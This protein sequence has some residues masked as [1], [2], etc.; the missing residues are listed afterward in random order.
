MSDFGDFI[1]GMLLFIGAILLIRYWWRTWHSWWGSDKSSYVRWRMGLAPIPD[2]DPDEYSR[3]LS[4]QFRRILG[5]AHGLQGAWDSAYAIQ[6]DRRLCLM[7][8]LVTE[9]AERL[10]KNHQLCSP[11]Y[12][13]LEYRT[14][15][16]LVEEKQVDDGYIVGYDIFVEVSPWAHD[17]WP[18]E[19]RFL[20]A[21]RDF[22]PI[23]KAK[24]IGAYRGNL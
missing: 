2:R 22:S 24:L 9:G 13:I 11:L 19:K 8:F 18:R 3:Y 1:G 16:R 5:D 17:S 15:L 7:E 6:E 23:T 20:G 14:P 4:L 10:R 12:H 21:Y